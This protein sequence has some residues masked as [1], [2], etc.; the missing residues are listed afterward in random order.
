MGKKKTRAKYVSKGKYPVTDKK[1]S[2][3]VRRDRPET[4]KFWK[5]LQAYLKGK[6]VWLTIPNPNPNETNKRFIKILARD[7]W[8]DPK[9]FKFHVKGLMH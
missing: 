9:S 7:Y 2:N 3:A 8:G 4:E 5:Q 1:L 6:R